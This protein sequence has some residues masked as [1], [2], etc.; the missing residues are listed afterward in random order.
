MVTAQTFDALRR[1]AAEL[2]IKLAA[3][4]YAL[5]S[6]EQEVPVWCWDP[7]ETAVA[8][9]PSPTTRNPPQPIDRGGEGKRADRARAAGARPAS[10]RLRAAALAA[11]EEAWEALTTDELM[12]AMD[13]P[14]WV[15]TD[16]LVDLR[17]E[18]VVW[19]VETDHWTLPPVG[20]P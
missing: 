9:E 16:V 3:I 14:R 6:I 4:N 15:A 2:R 20:V 18:G 12:A 1:E 7:E 17:D 11:L 5:E 19:E 13:C 10:T 8:A